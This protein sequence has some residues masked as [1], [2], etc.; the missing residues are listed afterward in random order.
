MSLP[1]PDSQLPQQAPFVILAHDD[2][3]FTYVHDQRGSL[4]FRTVRP[5]GEIHAWGRAGPGP[6]EVRFPG[7]LFGDS[8]RVVF[9]EIGPRRVTVFDVRDASFVTEGSWVDGL[10]LGWS[11]GRLLVERGFAGA[12]NR[13]VLQAVSIDPAG[14]PRDIVPAC[15]PVLRSAAASWPSYAWPPADWWGDR[16]VVGL[17]AVPALVVFEGSRRPVVIP[18]STGLSIEEIELLTEQVGVPDVEEC[19]QAWARKRDRSWK[20]EPP[21]FASGSIGTDRWGR[22]WL[23]VTGDPAQARLVLVDGTTVRGM[24]PIPCEPTV[25]FPSFAVASDRLVVGCMRDADALAPVVIQ[26]YRIPPP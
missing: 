26:V 2:G 8:S 25:P 3:S 7:M 24:H 9:A 14:E 15:H 1:I 18:L 11:R 22:I 19:P 21:L 23:L 16:L 10:P 17:P 6:G 13:T 4:L 20:Y 12:G 5:D